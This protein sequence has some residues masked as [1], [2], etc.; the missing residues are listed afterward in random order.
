MSGCVHQI[1]ESNLIHP[2]KF[3]VFSLKTFNREVVGSTLQ[4]GNHLFMHCSFVSMDKNLLK[5]IT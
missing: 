4:Y 1:T 2:M 5:A 3:A